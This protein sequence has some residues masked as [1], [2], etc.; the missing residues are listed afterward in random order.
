M[1]VIEHDF[2]LADRL[3][4]RRFARLLELDALHEANIRAN[5]LPYL[6]RAS[7]RIFRLSEVLHDALAASKNQSTEDAVEKRTMVIDAAE[8]DRLNKC[9]AILEA[10]YANFGALDDI[11]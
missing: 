10:G 11:M 3:T 4:E 7:E 8:Y 5:P 9:I 2:G 1:T 6:E